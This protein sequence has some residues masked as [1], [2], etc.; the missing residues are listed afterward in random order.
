MFART[1]IR[2]EIPI[3]HRR[4]MPLVKGTFWKGNFGGV[5]RWYDKTLMAEPVTSR[6]SLATVD[7]EMMNYVQQHRLRH[8]QL[9]MS[10]SRRRPTKIRKQREAN[11]QQRRRQRKLQTAF[12]AYMQFQVKR[13]LETQAALASQYGQASVNA[14]L[15]D[16]D[17][18]AGKE[19]LC[20]MIERKVRAPVSVAPVKRHQVT[21]VQHHN[22]RFDLRWRQE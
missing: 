13:T 5:S 4:A 6:K 16:Y 17:T 22:D 3:Y 19:R 14:A 10:Y 2:R 9:A 15:G 18:A 20:T 1:T 21:R 8:Q 12:K 11:V 7:R